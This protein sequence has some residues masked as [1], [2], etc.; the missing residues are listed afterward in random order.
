[1]NA[2]RTK[3]DLV[4]EI[5]EDLDCE[6]VGRKEIVAIENAVRNRFGTAAVESPMVIARLLADEGAELRHAEIMKLYVE[7]AADKPYDAALRNI[8]KLDDLTSAESSIR[9][10]DA[11][12]LKLAAEGDK[13]GLRLLRQDVIDARDSAQAAAARQTRSDPHESS[14]QAE[15]A[16][17]L[18]LWLHSPELFGQWLKLRKRSSDFKSRFQDIDPKK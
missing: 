5:W 11:L 15:I 2:S 16:E 18:T 4:I 10:I 13:E 7:R 8:L 3:A 14:S 9:N 1:M 6:S 17:W 12:R